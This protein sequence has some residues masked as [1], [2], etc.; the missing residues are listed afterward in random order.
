MVFVTVWQIV[1]SLLGFRLWFWC[2]LL[3]WTSGLYLHCASRISFFFSCVE[4]HSFV[5]SFDFFDDAF[6][7]LSFVLFAKLF[8]LFSSCARVMQIK[9][10]R[11]KIKT[12]FDKYIGRG[13]CSRTK[14]DHKQLKKCKF[15]QWTHETVPTVMKISCNLAIS[16]CFHLDAQF[17]AN[18]RPIM[19][20]TD[21]HKAFI[22]QCK[23]TANNAWYRHTQSIL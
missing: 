17:S 12:E 23:H 20:G 3:L 21:T 5:D 2:A 14:S 22:I 15:V 11:D 13:R 6:L 18:T 1:V 16:Q 9:E 7:F 8:L 10:V 19:R 4:K